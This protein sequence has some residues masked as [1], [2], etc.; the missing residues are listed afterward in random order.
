MGAVLLSTFDNQEIYL[1]AVTGQ[2]D[3]KGVGLNPICTLLLVSLVMGL[4]LGQG[5]G[6]V[7]KHQ[8]ALDQRH[9]FL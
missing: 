7:T 4:S 8:L 3:F 5:L 6:Q 2:A 9:C 1:D